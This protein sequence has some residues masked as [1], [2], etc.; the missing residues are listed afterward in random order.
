MSVS[1]TTIA[2]ISSGR[3][4]AIAL[5]RL[6]GPQAVAITDTVFRNAAHKPLATLPPAMLSFGRIVNEKNEIIDEVMAVWFQAPRSYTGENMV[7]ISCHGSSYIQQTILALLI[8]AGAQMAAPG[9]F[10]QRAYLNGKLDLVQAEAVA[11]LIASDSRASHRLAMNQMRGGY[12]KEFSDLRS[13]LLDLAALLELELDFSEEDVEFANRTQLK[14]VLETILKRI[15]KLTNSFQK[16]NAL[17]NGIPVAIVGHPNAGK[18]TLLNALLKEDR[19]IVSDIA[20]TTRDVIEETVNINGTS[21]RFIDTAGIRKTEDTLE[22]LG[23]NRTFDRLKKAEIVILVTECSSSKD[24]ILQEVNDLSLTK[25]QSLII[26][27]NK[28]DLFS[29]EEAI[30]QKVSIEST[31]NVP[32]FILSAKRTGDTFD[33]ENYLGNHYTDELTAETVLINNTRHYEILTRSYQST[34]SA[35]NALKNGLPTDLIAQDI[36]ETITQIG[37]LTGEITNEDILGTIFGKFCIGK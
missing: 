32:V 3:G 35:L 23:I 5:I 37:E 13:Q 8:N 15:E 22:S 11:D 2:A 16:G 31:L 29:Q 20:G 36:R 25:E 33:L 12:S 17:K 21:F 7:E 34:Y 26:I 18:S 19:A 14:D 27:L 9:E 4:G 1:D 28:V 6:S 30:K 10:T 24:Q